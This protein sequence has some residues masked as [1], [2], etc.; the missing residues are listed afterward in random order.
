MNSLGAIKHFFKLTVILILLNPVGQLFG[1]KDKDF[2]RIE[3]KV[4]SILYLMTGARPEVELNKSDSSG[5]YDCSVKLDSLAKMHVQELTAAE[6]NSEKYKQQAE[7]MQKKH[8]DLQTLHD[9]TNEDFR[10]QL[11]S[12]LQNS[13][14]GGTSMGKEA[15]DEL[16][17]LAQAYKTTNHKEYETFVQT[18]KEVIELE[19]D[20]NAMVDFEKVKSKAWGL[21]SKTYSYPGLQKDVIQLLF[22]LENYCAYEQRLLE[23]IAL[24]QTQSSDENRKKQLL[25]RE[26]SFNDYP[27][28]KAEIEKVKANQDYTVTPKCNK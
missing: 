16:L 21:H 22:K 9:K 28:L 23:V 26:D 7:Q 20:F 15:A 11:T 27:S 19:N 6:A 17:A 12:I 2:E 10:K 14:L 18:F 4:D 5:V 13:M 1:Q 8:S 3:K 25:R 24:S